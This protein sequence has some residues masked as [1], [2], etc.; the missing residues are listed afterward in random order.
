MSRQRIDK[1]LAAFEKMDPKGSGRISTA[2]IK[3]LY[4]AR[5]HPDYQNGDFTEKELTEQVLCRY[6]FYEMGRNF[7]IHLDT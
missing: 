3:S 7:T 4:N 1:I 2:D 6:N 5:N